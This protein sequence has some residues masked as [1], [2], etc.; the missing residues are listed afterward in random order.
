[1]ILHEGDPSPRDC[2]DDGGADFLLQRGVLC[3]GSIGS[4]ETGA[5]P[6]L[7]RDW[8]WCACDLVRIGLWNDDVHRRPEAER[9]L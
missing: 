3:G 8:V 2:G 5:S 9:S 4:D 6:Y 7:P 1:M